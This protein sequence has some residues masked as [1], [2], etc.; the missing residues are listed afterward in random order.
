ML[1]ALMQRPV[2]QAAIY[3]SPLCQRVG[4]TERILINPIN[5]LLQ[6]YIIMNVPRG[7]KTS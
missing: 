2:I 5:S 3:Y 7:L 1:L 6:H 4:P